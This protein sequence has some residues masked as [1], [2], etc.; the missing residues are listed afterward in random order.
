M[1]KSTSITLIL[2]MTFFSNSAISGKLYRWVD[3][4][5]NVSFSDKVP[6]KDSSRMRETLNESG[7]T[8]ATK[9]AAR[10]PAQLKQAKKILDVQQLQ[11]KLLTRQLA[12]D[13]A[14]LKTFQSEADIN[15]QFSS[16][17][18]MLNSHIDI[19][20]SQS[21]I[22]KKQLI[23]HQKSAANYE[24]NGQEIPA[25]TLSN[26]K[27]AQDQ[28]DRNMAGIAQLQHQKADLKTQLLVDKK[29]FKALTAQT[30]APSAIDQ[31]SISS[32]AMGEIHC[33]QD[34]IALWKSASDF[35]ANNSNMPIIYTS[36]NLLLTQN[37]RLSQQI[38]LNLTKD[39]QVERTSI[40]LDLR[41]ADSK[42]GKETCKSQR[43]SQI[44]QEFLQL[45]P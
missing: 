42:G 15:N 31:N 21:G 40:Y 30:N 34:C 3:A 8:I 37:P 27:S 29:R 14:L 18:N 28:F 44:V 38:S 19:A 24:R 39:K 4:Q 22:L 1:K 12:Q 33:T 32:L 43:T 10:T 13:S 2:L 20:K 25:K 36:E 6:P 11:I 7:R 26:I 45:N 41:C 5:G 17:T 35:I 16:K 23:T 9:D